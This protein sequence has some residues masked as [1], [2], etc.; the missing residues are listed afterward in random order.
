MLKGSSMMRRC[1]RW[2]TRDPRERLSSV[3]FSSVHPHTEEV[4]NLEAK[5]LLRDVEVFLPHVG[6]LATNPE[7]VMKI[8]GYIKDYYIVQAMDANHLSFQLAKT[9]CCPYFTP[10]LKLRAQTILRLSY[11]AQNIFLLT[12]IRNFVQY[13]LYPSEEVEEEVHVAK[14]PNLNKKCRR[15]KRRAKRKNKPCLLKLEAMLKRK[16]GSSSG[17]E[18]FK[19]AHRLLEERDTFWRLLQNM[20]QQVKDLTTEVARE[21]N[22]I[23]SKEEAL[24]KE[25]E[26]EQASESID[27]VSRG[28]IEQAEAVDLDFSVADQDGSATIED[29]NT[30]TPMD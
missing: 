2:R 4:R 13:W 7:E 23:T 19:R 3:G 11:R 18:K 30:T 29:L 9:Y 22:A 21:K 10:G 6:Q 12:S 27:E 25:I 16:A 20:D 5:G 24:N 15:R 28:N 26:A 14:A 1:K 8:G 17:Q